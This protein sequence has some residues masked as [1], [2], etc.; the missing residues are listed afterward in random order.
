MKPSVILGLV[1]GFA[2]GLSAGIVPVETV[3]PE[4]P[5]E[6]LESAFEGCAVIAVVIGPDGSVESAE[7]HSAAH[8]AFGEAALAAAR[9]WRFEPVIEEGRAVSKRVHIPFNFALGVEERMNRLFQRPVFKSLDPA[10]T[11]AGPRDF[12]PRLRPREPIR[13]RYP[14]A[15][16]GSGRTGRVTMA[17]VIDTDGRPINPEI[18]ESDDD[19][20]AR[21]AFVAVLRATFPEPVKDGKPVYVA[22]R[23]NFEFAEETAPARPRP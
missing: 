19:L 13:P 17:F 7:V 8:P 6:L 1:L 11:V 20:F 5:A 9:Q 22:M 16:K 2:S 18:V 12:E 23:R 4:Y 21:A 10:I 14:E 15:F 3:G